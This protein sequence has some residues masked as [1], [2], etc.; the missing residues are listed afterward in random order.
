MTAIRKW[1]RGWNKFWFDP[2]ETST[3][4][5]VR[6]AFGVVVLV[7]GL[8]LIPVLAPLFGTHGL[9]PHRPDAVGAGIWSVFDVADQD[10]MVSA[11][12]VLLLA[13]SSTLI[14]GYRA[15]LS[16]V[17]VFVMLLALQR[18]NPLVSNSG[19]VLLRTTGFYLMLAP[20]AVAVSVDSWRKRGR[21]GVWDCPP[22]APW[23]LRLIQIQ[24]T[25]V[26]LATVWAKLRGTTWNDG[27]ATFYALQLD[28][29]TRFPVP[30]AVTS[31]EIVVNL[32]TYGTLAIETSVAVLIWNR[33]ARPYVVAAGLG[34]HLVIDYS[35]RVGFFGP[36]L[37]V[38]Y[39][40]FLPPE[41]AT[42]L[43][44]IVKKLR[45]TAVESR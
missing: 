32:M 35:L 31:S 45:P 26:Y 37:L 29:L 21:S 11:V 33:T 44:D 8:S 20:T 34:L 41:R 42:R 40:A 38:S 19:D 14:V 23:P 18:R 25:V 17:V 9:L 24:L 16:S 13:S 7:W 28:D 6:V 10:L 1:V 3:L 5:I 12:L 27:T 36:A 43:L 22:R 4:V 15:R 2:M 30:Q 39:L